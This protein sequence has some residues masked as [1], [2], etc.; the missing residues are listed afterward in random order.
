MYDQLLSWIRWAQCHS[1]PQILMWQPCRHF[2]SYTYCL[3]DLIQS[4]SCGYWHLGVIPRPTPAQDQFTVVTLCASLPFIPHVHPTVNPA[5]TSFKIQKNRGSFHFTYS[6][7]IHFSWDCCLSSLG[8]SSSCPST[9]H[10]R[11]STQSDHFKTTLIT[12][13]PFAIPVWFPY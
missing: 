1:P 4:H 12:S 9:V 5:D 7:L 2:S 11:H 10:S 8:F 3:G 6:I 13:L